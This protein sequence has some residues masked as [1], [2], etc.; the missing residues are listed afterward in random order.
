MLKNLLPAALTCLQLLGGLGY[1]Q[2]TNNK[3]RPSMMFSCETTPFLSVSVSTPKSDSIPQVQIKLTDPLS[4]GQGVKVTGARIPNSHYQDVVEAPKAPDYSR[5]H[6]VEICG[7][8]EGEYGLTIYEHGDALYRITVGVNVSHFISDN[9]H[10]REGRTRRYRFSF[11]L[12]ND[13]VDLTWLD[14]NG[15]PQLN[16]DDNNW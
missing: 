15:K 2:A 7:A 11:N 10:S 1:G 13:Q 14:K 3:P 6:A 16:L 9:L 12:T 5:V 4:R 8:Q